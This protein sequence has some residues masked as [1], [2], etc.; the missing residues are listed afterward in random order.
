MIVDFYR[1]F[2][3]SVLSPTPSSGN[4]QCLKNQKK[5]WQSKVRQ[6]AS[7]FFCLSSSSSW[8]LPQVQHI[9]GLRGNIRP[10]YVH[11]LDIDCMPMNPVD[12][13]PEALRRQIGVPLEK[14]SAPSS[15]LVKEDVNHVAQTKVGTIDNV[16]T[17]QEAY[18]QPHHQAREADIRALSELTHALDKKENLLMELRNAN[19]D[20]L[21]NQNDVGYFKDSESFKSKTASRKANQLLIFL[22]DMK[23]LLLNKVYVI[24]VLDTFSSS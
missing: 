4:L 11:H 24:N 12:N 18:A 6:I 8:G 21:E 15:T 16:D 3:E 13:M 5:K 10:S 23:V 20:I 2:P 9:S 19:N 17:L 1:R 7:T 22:E 14:L